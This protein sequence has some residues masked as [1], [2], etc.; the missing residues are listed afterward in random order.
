[1]RIALLATLVGFAMLTAPTARADILDIAIQVI[2]PELKPA[3]PVLMCALKGNQSVLQC[4]VAGGKAEIAKEPLVQDILEVYGYADKGDWAKLV[5]KVGVTAVCTAFEI[6]VPVKSTLC[7]EYA[8][9]VVK[10]GAKIIEAHAVVAKEVGVYVASLVKDGAAVLTCAMGFSCP[11]SAK[12]PNRYDVTVGGGVVYSLLKFNL[13]QMWSDCYATRIEEGISARIADTVKFQRM[14]AAPSTRLGNTSVLDDDAL[15]RNCIVKIEADEQLDY[16]ERQQGLYARAWDAYAVQMNAKWRDMIFVATAQTLEHPAD[17]FLKSSDNWV[18]LRSI[19]VAQD[20]WDRPI[21]KG[22]YAGE[23]AECLR[24]VEFPASSVAIWSEG[25]TTVGDNSVLEGTPAAQWAGKVRGW[26]A[27][28]YIPVLRGKVEARLLAKAKAIA[29]GCTARP[30]GGLSCPAAAAGSYTTSAIDQCRTAYSGRPDACALVVLRAAAP[31]VAVAPPATGPDTSLV[32]PRARIKIAP[33]TAPITATPEPPP[34]APPG[35]Q[36][37][38]RI[39]PPIVP[40][41][42]P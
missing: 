29:G 41:P 30:E 39:K 20:K 15:G 13:D 32:L 9:Y 27:R 38:P 10:Y 22:V 16:Y 8:K 34:P 1:M 25:A 26:C 36:P 4:A 3:K 31:P 14:V 28:E 19:V 2:K 7:D 6:P 17:I 33:V 21:I 12:N 24:A 5:A 11:S 40:Q 18:K 37:L 35:A 42:K 23:T